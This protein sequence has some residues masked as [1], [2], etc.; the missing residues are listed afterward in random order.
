LLID[1][2]PP[3]WTLDFV[4]SKV[5]AEIALR[6]LSESKVVD[7]EFMQP[8]GPF[9]PLTSNDTGV[10]IGV[11]D[12][13]SAWAGPNDIPFVHLIAASLNLSFPLSST[14][15]LFVIT[16]ASFSSTPSV[17][18]E[19]KGD[20]INK[21]NTV[22]TGVLY[23]TSS[24]RELTSRAVH[25][26]SSKFIGRIT[27]SSYTFSTPDKET[28]NSGNVSLGLATKELEW[29]ARIKELH[30]SS[31]D[32]DI[33]HS[34]LLTASRTPL[35]PKVPPPNSK[36]IDTIL[37]E[38]RAQLTRLTP[39]QAVTEL[40]KSVMDVPTVLVDIRPQAQREE[41]GMIQGALIV[42]RNVLEWR[43]DPRCQ[44]RLPVAD[45]YD[46]RVIVFCQEGYTSR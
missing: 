12:A 40:R 44:A 25:L 39:R 37:E 34:I 14:P 8:Q 46:L 17:S 22:P 27:S 26:T 9:Y 43:F 1:D 31:F 11:T 19:S 13:S 4:R 45:R 23:V 15:Y 7:G 20:A 21:I 6:A 5:A 24:S 36:S 28:E 32:S 2:P 18:S 16:A 33:I 42:E 10:R 38:A 29:M 30:F 41:F 3:K 35:D